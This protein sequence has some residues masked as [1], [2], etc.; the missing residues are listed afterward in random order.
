[1]KTVA[2]RST[3]LPVRHQPAVGTVGFLDESIYGG[4]AICH[5]PGAAPYIL[6]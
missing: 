5:R 1:M 4:G 6:R 3:V 2:Q